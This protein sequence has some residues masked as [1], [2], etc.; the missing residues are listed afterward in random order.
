MLSFHNALLPLCGQQ[1]G[2]QRA[3]RLLKALWTRGHRS[4]LP[5]VLHVIL[6]PST[7]M[8]LPYT[9]VREAS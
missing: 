3:Y 9:T 7:D 8:P 4:Q 5:R 2:C 1:D 6:T